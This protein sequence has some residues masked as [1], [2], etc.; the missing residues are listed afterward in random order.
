MV[1][2]K[3]VTYC[4]NH[5]RLVT[6]EEDPHLAEH[7]DHALVEL[8][9]TGDRVDIVG[10]EPGHNIITPVSGTNTTVVSGFNTIEDAL[11]YVVASGIS[12]LNPDLQTPTT[13]IS[14]YNTLE[15]AI[16]DLQET[17]AT[18]TYVDEAI[19]GVSGGGQRST[20]ISFTSGGGSTSRP[21][22]TVKSTD[23]KVAASFLFGGTDLTGVPSKIKVAYSVKRSSSPGSIRI[24]DLT[25]GNLISS[26]DSL[27]DTEE[28]ILDLGTLQNVPAS[29]A[30][31][32]IQ[33]KTSSSSN[34][35]Y[36]NS[37]TIEY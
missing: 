3:F 2:M 12:A 14:G 35:I 7:G 18:E 17:Y 22:V 23:Y 24:F 1:E 34:W 11:N 19:A 28:A 4:L 20:V 30:L 26:K 31:L 33:A 37:L 8:I 6:G 27:V 15:E 32:E 13:S 25:N 36:I 16:I 9:L 10:N 21:Y 5:G 29:E